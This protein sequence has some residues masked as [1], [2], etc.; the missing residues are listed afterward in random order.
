MNKKTI[1][2]IL[3]VSLLTISLMATPTYA[4]C[5][6]TDIN[7][8]TIRVGSRGPMVKR[9]Q[10]AMNTLLN[11]TLKVDGIYGK[12]TAR[13]L[14]GLQ[15]DLNVRVDGVIGKQTYGAIRNMLTTKCNGDETISSDKKN[16]SHTIKT[17][18]SE[19]AAEKFITAGLAN[20]KNK[21]NYALRS[22]VAVDFAMPTAMME[23]TDNA[24]M[25]EVKSDGN[26]S[27]TNTQ[28]QNVDESDIIKTDGEYIYTLSGKNIDIIKTEKNGDLIKIKTI[29]LE[30]NAHDM[31][32]DGGTLAVFTRV[33]DK[34]NII[35]PLPERKIQISSDYIAPHRS[36]QYSRVSFYDVSDTSHPK[37]EKEYDFEGNYK[38]SRITN[39]YLYIVS[40]KYVYNYGNNG[41]MPMLRE[42]GNT[43]SMIGNIF[44]FDMPY[45]SYHFTQVHGINMKNPDDMKESTY[46]L[47]GGHALY[48]SENSLYLSYTDHNHN[49][50]LIDDGDFVVTGPTEKTVIHK[51]DLDKGAS[52]LSATGS[53]PGHIVNQFA[54]SEYKGNL[55]IATTTGNNW[56]GGE[57]KNNLYVLDNNLEIIGSVT[58]LAPG[59]RIYSARFMGDTAYM[60]T[61]KQVDPLFVIDVSNPRKPK[62]KGK[63]KIPGFSSY[64][65]PYDKDTLLGIGRDVEVNENGGTTTKG[66]KIALFDVSNVSKPREIDSL[67][68]GSRSS[69]SESLNNHKAVLFSKEKNMLVIPFNDYNYGDSKERFNGAAVVLVD[70]TFGI[71]LKGKISHSYGENNPWRSNIQRTLYIDDV[72]YSMSQQ[73]IQSNSIE[74]LKTIDSVK[75]SSAQNI[76]DKYPIAV[77]TVDF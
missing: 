46:L 73:K 64:L 74:S 11:S 16:Y 55:R 31:Y 48:A 25:D 30:N 56:N 58:N 67:I 8:Q 65:H 72:L 61:F 50:I 35:M 62:V 76:Y 40:Q 63:L 1:T 33:Y 29:K 27:T 57:S 39:G 38:D 17:F 75:L 60:V 42:N 18:S 15:T 21:Q 5:N 70:A 10:A 14:R 7:G 26:Y 28:E 19:A 6:D 22:A 59:E 34:Q 69:H 3:L 77:D 66:I 32:L 12:N 45:Q 13:I 68:L 9:V 54:M 43:K 71:R 49:E 20:Q 41:V 4:S 53:A 51:I 24:S 2:S 23:S 37:L 47:S 36:I 52:K 44:Y